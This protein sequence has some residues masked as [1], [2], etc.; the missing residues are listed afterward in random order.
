MLFTRR[1]STH[2]RHGAA[3]I[4]FAL[5][6]VPLLILQLGVMEYSWFFFQQAN[7]QDAARV[8]ARIAA[9][10]EGMDTAASAA[11]AEAE[12]TLDRLGVDAGAATITVTSAASTDGGSTLFTVAVSC[13]YEPLLGVLV[14]LPTTMAASA[15]MVYER[16]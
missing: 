6:L 4:E 1:Q 5:L 15:T 7:V 12:L 9:R 13:P 16:D 2:T 8:G 11:Q 14:P 3:L 10:T